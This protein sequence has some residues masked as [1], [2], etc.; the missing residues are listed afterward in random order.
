[1]HPFHFPSCTSDFFPLVLSIHSIYS[2]QSSCQSK[3]CDAVD[4][5]RASK[6]EFGPAYCYNVNLFLLLHFNCLNIW[7]GF[8]AVVNLYSLNYQM[9]LYYLFIYCKH[10]R[11]NA[12]FCHW[13]HLALTDYCI[14]P[15][16]LWTGLS[17]WWMGESGRSSNTSWERIT[18]LEQ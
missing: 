8:P 10:C 2:F 18:N 6:K 13:H 14:L 5:L 9:W 7:G 11:G 15:D 3:I 16:S 4:F 1:M 12:C 17:G